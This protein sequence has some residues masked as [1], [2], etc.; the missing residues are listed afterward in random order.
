MAHGHE[1]TR[2]PG[3]Y[4]LSLTERRAVVLAK[5]GTDLAAL[6]HGGL[7][8]ATADGMIENVVGT[9]A[10]PFALAPNFRIDGC[11]HFV[12]MVVEEPSVVAA[13]ANAARMV[14]AGGGFTTEHDAPV[15]IAQVQL[16]DVADPDAACARLAAAEPEILALCAAAAPRIVERGGGPRNVTSR[17]LSR[18]TDPDG[19][20][21]VVHLHVDCRDAM[22]ANL[23]NGVAETVAASL[24]RIAGSGARVGLRILS[25]LAE[26]RLVRVRARV[27]A[28]A[29]ADALHTDGLAVRDGIVAASRFAELDP[30]RAATHNK[31]IMNGVDAVLV[32]TGNDWRGVEAGAHAYAARSGRYA[33]LAIWRAEGGDLHGELAMPMAVGTVGGA[34]QV[35][36][37]AQ[38]AIKLAGAHSARVLAALAGAAGLASNLAALRA[39]ATDGIQRGHMSLHARAVARG[40]GAAGPLLDRVAVAIAAEGDVR[41]E[42]ARAVLDELL[43]AELKSR[44]SSLT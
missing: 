3:F 20:M 38:L 5:T 25:N 21:V 23:V 35:H 8:L 11:D 41:P 17:V 31:G 27:P 2:I 18:P 24:A 13:A 44:Q 16:L 33:P 26:N 42:R 15:M 1:T 22:G 7:D 6:D 43:A 14:R 19:G 32:A 29:L 36:P 40:V 34:I 4:R 37:G 28:A 9:Y 12:P 10:L 30:F 39:L